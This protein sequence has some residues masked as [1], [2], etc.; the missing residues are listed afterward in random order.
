LSQSTVSPTGKPGHWVKLPSQ[1]GSL[2][3]HRVWQ[4]DDGTVFDP[5]TSRIYNV[6]PRRL[7]DQRSGNQIP[8]NVGR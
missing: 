1:T 5:E 3:A 2:L 7:P 4:N 6:D 8:S